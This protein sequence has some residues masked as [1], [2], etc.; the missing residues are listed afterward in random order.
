MFLLTQIVLKRFFDIILSITGL[1]IAV[2]PM[3]MISLCIKL[4]SPGPVLYHQKRVGQHGKPFI[5]YKFRTMIDGAE[6]DT[7]PVLAI[8]ND[9]RITNV[10]RFLRAT[11]MDEIPQLIFVLYVKSS[12]HKRQC[13]GLF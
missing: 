10:G 4:T 11:R 5:L 8:E 9:P 3:V 6:N 1:L 2:V 12:I 7:G 13:T